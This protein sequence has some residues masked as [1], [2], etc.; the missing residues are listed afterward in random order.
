VEFSV[1]RPS[2]PNTYSHVREESLGST[3]K[4]VEITY[5][6]S[7]LPTKFLHYVPY[8]RGVLMGWRN[9][10]K[11]AEKKFLQ[12]T[13]SGCLASDFHNSTY[14]LHPDRYCS[15]IVEFSGNEFEFDK[16]EFENEKDKITFSL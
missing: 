1:R 15:E 4:F 9:F 16:N 13:R 8:T 7:V 3:R 2:P 6:L 14:P 11:T 12:P 10:S 5:C